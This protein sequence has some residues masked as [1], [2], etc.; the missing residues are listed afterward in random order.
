MGIGSATGLEVSL[1]STLAGGTDCSATNGCGVHVHSGTACTDTDTQ[2]G[3]YY[4]EGI[5]D[6]WASIGY[7]S[8]DATG[9]AYF[10]FS[11]KGVPDI[12][13]KPFIVHNNAGGRVACGL[14]PGST[15]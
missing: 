3:H 15:S 11:V 13:F 8:T 5:A 9:K 6:P 7:H 1:Q 4:T 14:F 10:A 2:G 12:S